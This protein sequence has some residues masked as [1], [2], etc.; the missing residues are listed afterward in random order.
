MTTTLEQRLNAYRRILDISK[1]LNSTLEYGALLQQIVA[2]VVEIL[3]V[4]AASIMLQDPSTGELRFEIASNLKPHETERIAV[5]L[6]RSIAGWIFTHGEPRVIEDVTKDPKHY[7]QVDS[8]TQFVT[9]NLLGVPLRTHTKVIGVVQALNKQDGEKF[10]GEDIS[11]LTVLA[12]QAGVA[13]EN[14]R[15]FQQSDFVAEIV[16]ELRTPLAALRAS[17]VLLRRPDLP[18]AKRAEVYGLLEEETERLIALTSDF[19]D[20]ARLESGRAEMDRR[21][22]DL[23]GLVRDCVTLVSPQAAGKDIEIFIEIGEVEASGDKSKLKQV[24][25]NLLTNA[26]KYNRHGGQVLVS[27]YINEV[28]MVQVDVRDT[29]H[30]IRPENLPNMFRKFYRVADTANTVQ[31]TG[32]GLAICKHIIEAHGG[33]IW[34][35]S[36]VDEGTTFSFVLPF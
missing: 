24:L 2:A 32:L 35:E 9:R 1:Q 36:V 15:L 28:G 25:L 11:L 34:V 30:G 27:G 12:S 3:N 5:P 8:A 23:A 7:R 21:A 33:S 16:H 14:A 6:D 22:F 20:L 31:G 4:E 26:I 17:T 13:I 10:N 19:L 18:E 29:G